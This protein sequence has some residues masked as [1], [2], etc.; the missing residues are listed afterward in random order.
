MLHRIK[1]IFDADHVPVVSSEHFG[2]LHHQMGPIPPNVL[3]R[4][5]TVASV[6]SPGTVARISQGNL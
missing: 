1:W 5:D 2:F 3:G 4:R 6:L